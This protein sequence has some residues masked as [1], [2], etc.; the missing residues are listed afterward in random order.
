MTWKET[1]NSLL[2]IAARGEIELFL[3]DA[4]LYLELSGIVCI[5]WQWLLQGIAVQKMLNSNAGDIDTNFAEGKMYTLNYFYGYEIPR[6]QG[7]SIRLKNADGITLKMKPEY[8]E[9]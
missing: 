5:A 6:I 9:D 8:F 1:T 3:A 4:T 2:A 7:L